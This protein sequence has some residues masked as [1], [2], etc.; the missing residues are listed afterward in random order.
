VS[1]QRSGV[2]GK[3]SDE[4]AFHSHLHAVGKFVEFHAQHLGLHFCPGFS[5]L[6]WVFADG[7]P[8]NE[9]HNLLKLM[10]RDGTMTQNAESAFGQCRNSG[11]HRR[12]TALHSVSRCALDALCE[13]EKRMLYRE[14]QAAEPE[15]ALLD[16]VRKRPV[17][18]G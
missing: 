8:D 3:I 9:R 16:W 1:D 12:R 13:H 2:L 6:H 15:E 10:E 17:H 11:N 18:S 7:V 5:A 14:Y 4:P